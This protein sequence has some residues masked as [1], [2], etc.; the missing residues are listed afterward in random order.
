MPYDKPEATDPMMFMGVALP[1]D[2]GVTRDM[3]YTFAEEFARLGHSEEKILQL[4][5]TPFYRGAHG[6]YQALGEEAVRKIVR[7]CVGVW[8]RVRFVDRD[9]VPGNREG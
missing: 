4:F 9:T 1:G 2:E 7:E 8:G 6:A 5:R 3:A